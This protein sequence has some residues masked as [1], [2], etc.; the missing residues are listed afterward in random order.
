MGGYHGVMLMKAL[1][2]KYSRS[3]ANAVCGG[4]RAS[5]S[6]APALACPTQ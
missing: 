3:G 6:L 2:F 1:D 4:S 5:D